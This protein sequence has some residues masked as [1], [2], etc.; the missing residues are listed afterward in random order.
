MMSDSVSTSEHDDHHMSTEWKQ[1]VQLKHAPHASLLLVT[2]V[3][4]IMNDSM[5]NL[6]S[7]FA[8]HAGGTSNPKLSGGSMGNMVYALSNS[9]IF[10]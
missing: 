8:I 7:I 1:G 4:T 6:S 5:S 2:M 3:M 10:F 9:V